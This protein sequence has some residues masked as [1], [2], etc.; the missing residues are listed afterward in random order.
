MLE[1]A[2]HEDVGWVETRSMAVVVAT[3]LEAFEAG[4]EDAMTQPRSV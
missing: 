2:V 4:S 1:L 3:A